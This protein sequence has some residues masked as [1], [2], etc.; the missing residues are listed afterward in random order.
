MRTV[1]PLEGSAWSTVHGVPRR[2]RVVYPRTATTPST[3]VGGLLGLAA[4]LFLA[5]AVAARLASDDAPPDPARTIDP[6]GTGDRTA[7]L[8]DPVAATVLHLLWVAL[9]ACL[10]LLVVALVDLVWRTD[11]TGRVID[12]RLQERLADRGTRGRRRYWIAIDDGRREPVRALRVGADLFEWAVV[13]ADVHLRV[14][15][16]TRYAH[17]LRVRTGTTEVESPETRNLLRWYGSPEWAD[18]DR[19]HEDVPE[20]TDVRRGR[21]ADPGTPDPADPRGLVTAADAASALGCAVRGEHL[22]VLSGGEP[23]PGV[24]AW[25]YLP[26]GALPTSQGQPADVV[27]VYSAANRTS[28][29]SMIPLIR[30]AEVWW[31]LG[32]A[33]P[34]RNVPG[35]RIPA[36]F[37]GTLLTVFHRRATFAVRVH[38]HGLADTETTVALVR[39][40]LDRL[41]DPATP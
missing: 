11:L 6:T 10:V 34:P 32:T 38:R 36:W 25:A 24:I 17:T 3:L 9:L 7:P 20:A 39:T 29:A 41:E 19:G 33:R 12:R 26:V 4:L 8:A 13:G 15:R 1:K 22:P 27:E 28:A 37:H 35:M 14:S 30:D 2:V 21:H 18:E 23:V 5:A 16:L 40:V 31:P